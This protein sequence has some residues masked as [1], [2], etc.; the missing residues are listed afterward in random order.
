MGNILFFYTPHQRL[1]MITQIELEV[2]LNHIKAGDT[3]HF[4]GCSGKKNLGQC[5]TNPLANGYFC[6]T[7]KLT[8]QKIASIA[9][10]VMHHYQPKPKV[11]IPKFKNVTE[12]KEYR[13]KG[14]KVG[15]GV[16]SW[17]ISLLREHCFDT[18][19]YQKRINFET[20][21]MMQVVDT[22][23]KLSKELTPSLVYTFN[24]RMSEYAAVVEWCRVN[25]Q[26]F[27]VYEF[28]SRKDEYHIINNTIPHDVDYEA[29][30]IEKYWAREDVSTGEKIRIGGSFY[31]NTR[32]GI[33]MLEESFIT[34]QKAGELPDFAPDKE[35]ITFF[36]SSID[37]Y[38]AVPGWEE[39]VYLFEDETEAIFQICD[40]FKND[41]TKQFV[42]RI[43]PNLKYLNNTQ[44]RNLKKLY[45]LTNLIIV[46][47]TS[48]VSSYTLLDKSDK[49]ITFG[50]TLGIEATYFGKPSILL[51]LCF[52]KYLDAAYTPKD[53]AELYTLIDNRELAAKPQENAIKYGYWWVTFGEQYQHR[54]ITYQTTALNF[55]ISEKIGILSC[56]ILSK[57]IPMRFYKL[58]QPVT[59]KK[60]KDKRF[61]QSLAREFLPWSKK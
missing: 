23:E 57:E 46:E 33:S 17:I 8:Q 45:T 25:K 39:Y 49:V 5:V 36:N 30:D 41:T 32:A 4:V 35:I 37:E 3:I 44:T 12:L 24:G 48:K 22:I 51:G 1:G 31:E 40:H 14:V 13:Y 60:I 38:A 18:A 26:P 19:R 20:T 59:Y 52:F 55:N 53:R 15:V 16:A 42:I 6:H 7:C 21:K 28:T 50:S 29:A 58:L 2:I 11:S 56:K 10:V 34:A 47:A 9:N 27:K 43:H 54:D 61:R